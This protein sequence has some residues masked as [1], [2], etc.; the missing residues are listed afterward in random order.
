MISKFWEIM[1]LLITGVFFFTTVSLRLDNSPLAMYS[2][3]SS[4]ILIILLVNE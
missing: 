2:A 1:A 4:W 3:L